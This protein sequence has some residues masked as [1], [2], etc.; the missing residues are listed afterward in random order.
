MIDFAHKAIEERNKKKVNPIFIPSDSQPAVK[1]FCNICRRY[2]K[3]HEGGVYVCLGCGKIHEDP[4]KNADRLTNE[5][6]TEPIIAARRGNK[7]QPSKDLPTGATW[8]RETE[9]LPDGTSTELV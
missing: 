3:Y 7:K 8:L 1:P 6:K 2:M 9:H 5:F 4:E